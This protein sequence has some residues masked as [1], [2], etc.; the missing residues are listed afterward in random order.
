MPVVSSESYFDK[1]QHLFMMHDQVNFSASAIKISYSGSETLL[2]QKRFR[3]L[4][5][6]VTNL[7][8]GQVRGQCSWALQSTGTGRPRE[9]LAQAGSCSKRPSWFIYSEPI[10]PG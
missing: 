5:P 9:N 4:L 10:A 1:D 6:V 8:G 2:M 7:P 3:F